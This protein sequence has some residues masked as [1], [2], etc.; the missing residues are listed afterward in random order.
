MGYWDTHPVVE[1]VAPVI[2]TFHP[3]FRSAFIT[4]GKNFWP[5]NDDYFADF[6]TA[7]VMADKYGD[8]KVYELPFPGAG[9]MF[10]ATANIFCT[11]LK[12]GRLVNCGV[13]AAFYVRN[14]EAQF[15]GLAEKLV[16]LNLGE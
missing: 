2:V 1:G 16:R 15:P 12:S 4:D 13:L 10:V 8:G 14:P 6:G 9:G 11:K 3:T 5:L 7:Q